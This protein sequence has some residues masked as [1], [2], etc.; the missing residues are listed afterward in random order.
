M[1]YKELLKKYMQHVQ[2]CESITFVDHIGS[3]RTE[4]DFT[5]A[6]KA[7]LGRIEDELS[8]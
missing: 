2:S 5:D 4:V 8:E 6:E 3:Y 7:E 1:D